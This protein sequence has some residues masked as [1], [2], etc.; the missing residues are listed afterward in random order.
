MSS[1]HIQPASLSLSLS[2]SLSLSRAGSLYACAESPANENLLEV[3]ERVCSPPGKHQEGSAR[4]PLSQ[5]LLCVCVCVCVCVSVCLS[6]CL[7]AS[8]C[9]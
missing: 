8:S 2:F 1:L 7:C 3:D 4:V 9:T 6:V 5:L